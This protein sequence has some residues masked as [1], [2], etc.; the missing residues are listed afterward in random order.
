MDPPDLAYADEAWL[1]SRLENLESE[2]DSQ[3]KLLVR[4]LH[5]RDQQVARLNKNF[6]KLTEVMKQIARDTGVYVCVCVCVCACVLCVVYVCVCVR[7]C[8]LSVIICYLI[9]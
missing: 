9:L 5:T 2:V 7:K 3:S 6:D 8:K 1:Q 4:L